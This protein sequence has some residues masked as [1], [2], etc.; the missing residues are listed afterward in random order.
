VNESCAKV[1]VN[2]FLTKPFNVLSG[3]RQG[4]PWA[5]LLFLCAIEPL[6]CALRNSE[7][8]G[9]ILPD[10]QRVIYS[11]Y[12]DDTTLFLSDL[13]DLQKAFHILHE[14]SA[15]SGMR[16][17]LSKCSAV[18]LG[19]LTE[20]QPPHSRPFKW[21]T[22]E[23]EMEKLLGLPV[24][25]FFAEDNIWQQILDKLT[26][27]IQHWSAQNLS[28]YGRVHAARS[29]MGGQAWFLANIVPPNTKSFKRSTSCFGLLSIIMQ[30]L[31]TLIDIIHHGQGKHSS[32]RN[33]KA[34]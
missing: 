33:P 11:G 31:K 16:L 2:S 3:V 24:N 4:C 13:Q 18:P 9:V 17:N 32:N 29:Y 21:L 10:G 5:P 28:I 30:T 12:A 27:S 6:A 34:V 22:V 26:K 23:S 15:I 1:I 25:V 20:A 7:L 8:K 14:Y 19:T